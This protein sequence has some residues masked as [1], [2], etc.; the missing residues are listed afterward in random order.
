MSGI[1][2]HNT[3]MGQRFYEHTVPE[4]VRQMVRLNENLERL[5]E[6]ADQKERQS[7]SGVIISSGSGATGWASSIHRERG[8]AFELPRGDS[9]VLAWFVREAWP[10]VATGTGITAGLLPSGASLEVISRMDD[11]VIFGDDIEGGIVCE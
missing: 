11:G 9:E 7:S 6:V 4:L 3:V 8:C 10:S 1:P 2:F 5:V